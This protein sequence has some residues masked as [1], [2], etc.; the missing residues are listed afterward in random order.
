MSTSRVR[1][2]LCAVGGGCVLAVAVFN[3][4]PVSV[5]F[6]PLLYWLV[7][8]LGRQW[9]G[10]PVAFHGTSVLLTALTLAV[11]AVPPLL[12]RLVLGARVGA[13]TFV[14]VWLAVSLLI[15]WPTLQSVIEAME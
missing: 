3:G 1:R 9:V 15:A 10:S 8:M 7:R 6:D 2:M 4:Q 14:L 12:A 11:A 5:Y 13:V